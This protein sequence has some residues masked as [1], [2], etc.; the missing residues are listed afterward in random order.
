MENDEG[1]GKKL[2]KAGFQDKVKMSDVWIL[3]IKRAMLARL[4]DK[5]NDYY[6]CIDSMLVIL[7]QESRYKMVGLFNYL[8]KHP[9]L[10]KDKK[11]M[12][13]KELSYIVDELK[14]LGYLSKQSQQAIYGSDNL[15]ESKG[16]DEL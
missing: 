15:E 16:D 6:R 10:Y 14:E 13:D 4:E 3:L 11:E 1:F 9:E 12:Y 2:D 7:F 8:K 5:T